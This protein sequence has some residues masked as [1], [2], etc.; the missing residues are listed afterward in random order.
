[1]HPPS[2]QKCLL[3]RDR[4]AP[5]LQRCKRIL[6][7][8]C[9]F[10]HSFSSRPDWI[11]LAFVGRELYHSSIWSLSQCLFVLVICRPSARDP[12]EQGANVASPPPPYGFRSRTLPFHICS[13]FKG[14]LPKQCSW[15]ELNSPIPPSDNYQWI[16]LGLGDQKMNLS[17]LHATRSGSD[18]DWH[19]GRNNAHRKL[20]T[21]VISACQVKECRQCSRLPY[22][23]TARPERS[24][25]SCA[26]AYILSQTLTLF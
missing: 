3:G 13:T 22:D 5:L 2:A 26:L 20:G 15:G 19:G 25:S 10:N 9:A 21:D 16:K 12:N 8:Q 23:H 6:Q 18:P 4:G 11:T 14:E 1:M 24:E 17:K 7:A